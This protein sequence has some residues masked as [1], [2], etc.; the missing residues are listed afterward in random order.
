MP[1]HRLSAYPE[2]LSNGLDG[3]L[4]GVVHLPGH[5]DLLRR[6]DRG[7]TTYPPPSP[8]N[9]KLTVVGFVDEGLALSKPPR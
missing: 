4:L 2:R 6:H 8:G 7:T 5:L 3:V 1:V 9:G